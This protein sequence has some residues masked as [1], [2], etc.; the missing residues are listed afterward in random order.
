MHRQCL[1]MALHHNGIFGVNQIFGFTGA[2]ADSNKCMDV[3]M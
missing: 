1:S 3:I 2:D